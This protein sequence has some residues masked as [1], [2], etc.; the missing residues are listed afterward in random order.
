M[1]FANLAVAFDQP[2][3]TLLHY[4]AALVFVEFL[5]HHR[6]REG[7]AGI[8]KDLGHNPRRILLPDTGPRADPVKH[9][10]LSHPVLPQPKSLRFPDRG[11]LVVI[12]IVER[13][14]C[15]PNQKKATH[16]SLNGF[17]MCVHG[18]NFHAAVE[19]RP[20]WNSAKVLPS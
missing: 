5:D 11:K 7:E 4:R 9:H 1:Q 20:W 18:T 16:A 17:L 10:L 14:L 6:F 15:M 8:A 13:C 12:L 2:R 19:S 3:E